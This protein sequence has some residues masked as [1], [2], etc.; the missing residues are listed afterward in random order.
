MLTK[1]YI[2]ETDSANFAKEKPGVLDKMYAES[3]ILCV[4]SAPSIFPE[5]MAW[6]IMKEALELGRGFGDKTSIRT[7]VSRKA[8]IRLDIFIPQVFKFGICCKYFRSRLL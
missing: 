2:W 6:K 5:R 3:R 4:D 8:L 1:L 7:F